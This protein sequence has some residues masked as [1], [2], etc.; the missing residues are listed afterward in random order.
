[1][2]AVLKQFRKSNPF[3]TLILTLVV[4][5]FVAAKFRPPFKPQTK[6]VTQTPALSSAAQAPTRAQLP[7]VELPSLELPKAAV[8]VVPPQTKVKPKPKHRKIVYR[9]HSK[10]NSWTKRAYLQSVNHYVKKIKEEKLQ[11]MTLQGLEEAPQGGVFSVEPF[12]SLTLL[13]PQFAL[14]SSIPREAP[15]SIHEG[16][17]VANDFGPI[18]QAMKELADIPELKESVVAPS[19][20]KAPEPVL[21]SSQTESDSPAE[22]VPEKE[23]S[24]NTE[25]VEPAPELTQAETPEVSQPQTIQQP[26][27]SLQPLQAS[28]VDIQAVI[29]QQKEALKSIQQLV[30]PSPSTQKEVTTQPAPKRNPNRSLIPG[31]ESSRVQEP[32]KL[33]KIFGKLTFDRKVQNWIE[34]SKGHVELHLRKERSKEP[35]D[36][37]FIEYQYPSRDFSLDGRDLEGSFE[38]VASFFRPDSSVAVAEVTYPKILESQT[39]KEMVVFHVRKEQVEDA[40]R[41][42]STKTKTGV[43]LSGT[44]FEGGSGDHRDV[45]PLS[46][47][48]VSVVGQSDWG[49]FESDKEGNFRIPFVSANSEYLLSV[50]A[51]GYFPTEVIVPT[52]QTTGYVS[53]H[54][55]PKDKV[56]VVT[57]YFTKRPQ[58]T[59]KAVIMGRLFDPGSRTPK[60]DQEVV[61]S[62]RNGRA[63]YFGA[64]PDKSLR[65]TTSTGLFGFFNVEPAFRSVG[66]P[67]AAASELINIKPG[68]G[69]YIE[70]GRGGTKTVRGTLIDPYRQQRL[71]GLVRVVGSPTQVETNERG[72]FEI[73]SIEL[74]P[75]I[76]TLEVEAQ[77]YPTSWHTLSWS[78]RESKKNHYLY[79]AEAELLNEVRTT[80]ARVPEAPHSGAILGGAES[81]FFEKSKSCVYVSLETSEGQPV[82]S[83]QGPFPLHRG[84]FN[85]SKP[86]CL[87]PQSP[88]F[89]YFNLTPGQYI[90][91]WK[92]KKGEVLRSH[93]TRVGADRTSILIN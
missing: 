64:L 46:G 37:L 41:A 58:G 75:G 30:A 13:D 70:M 34:V 68:S 87:V 76:I 16:V 73:D 57:Q 92:N 14:N 19:A 81:R 79:L 49:P 72:E 47:A 8:P 78:A 29:A 20:P 63:L 36:S 59:N 10:R 66:K 83:E 45:K 9:R 55:I 18:H 1:V 93:V 74:S 65:Q 31:V 91:K 85:P 17:L 44:V 52:F 3:S 84:D 61:L 77:G 22:A 53:V 60:A 4:C 82:S 86:L 27:P 24:V 80:V 12:E 89:S 88:G 62:G 38:L 39:A 69:Y 90:L 54:L 42:V 28:P 43:V 51:P 48:Q 67:T 6:H 2:K 23:I 7:S 5:F 32:E 26:T 21:V 25:V 40:I 11:E 33:G 35:Q 15:L 71:S 50:S 56:E